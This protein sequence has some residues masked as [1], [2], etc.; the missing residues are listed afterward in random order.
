M[1]RE[2]RQGGLADAD[3]AV[4]RDYLAGHQRPALAANRSVTHAPCA[5]AAAARSRESA[6]SPPSQAR[7]VSSHNRFP[8]S[9]LT[10]S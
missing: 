2:A 8:L 7:L 5:T 10:S 4:V 3:L 1:L 6:A 9:G